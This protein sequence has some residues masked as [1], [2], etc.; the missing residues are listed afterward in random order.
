MKKSIKLVAVMLTTLLGMQNIT[1]MSHRAQQDPFLR[2]VNKVSPYIMALATVDT[3]LRLGTKYGSAAV[4]LGAVATRGLYNAVGALPASLSGLGKLVSKNASGRNILLVGII[5][6]TA[7]AAGIKYSDALKQVG[8][9]L[10]QRLASFGSGSG[11]QKADDKAPTDGVKSYADILD[12]GKTHAHDFAQYL[13]GTE[14]KE[15]L[16]N[17]LEYAQKHNAARSRIV[18][19]EERL[20]ALG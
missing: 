3:G 9:M 13:A 2:A 19:I 6:G 12:Q 1:A 14:D 15:L 20:E 5:L 8:A 17:M 7:A 18:K 4:G 11:E 16:N 10:G